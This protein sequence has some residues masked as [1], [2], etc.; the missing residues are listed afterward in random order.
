MTKDE[1]PD[2]RADIGFDVHVAERYF[3][4]PAI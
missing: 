4:E 1:W 3:T 2:D